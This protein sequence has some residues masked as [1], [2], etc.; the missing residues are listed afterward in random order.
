MYLHGTDMTPLGIPL[1]A[2]WMGPASVP[3]NPGF[4]IWCLTLCFSASVF[5]ARKTRWLAIMDLSITVSTAPPPILEGH[6]SSG[7]LGVSPQ[8]W[9]PTRVRRLRAGCW[10]P[11][12]LPAYQLL[13]GLWPQISGW[14]YPYPSGIRVVFSAGY[15][16]PRG[17]RGPWI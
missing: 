3:P 4:L 1:P 6:L 10:K 13:L 9:P 15:S 16:S 2:R 14:V 5:S 12:G 8:L 11:R 17:R 7:T